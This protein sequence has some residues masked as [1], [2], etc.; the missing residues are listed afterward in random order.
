M[1][2][3][4]H[5]KLAERL[6]GILQ[7]LNEGENLVIDELLATY[8]VDRRTLQRD[9]NERLA[10]LP[11]EKVAQGVYR[12]DKTL[13][14]K[15]D[16]GDI[17][18]F[19]KFASVSELFHKIDQS[20]F[21]KY[22]KDSIQVKGFDYESIQDRQYEFDQILKAIDNHY[23]LSFRYKRLKN[24]HQALA[25]DYVVEPYRLVNKKGVWY[26]IATHNGVIKTFSLTRLSFLTPCPDQVFEP[27][28]KINQRIDTSDSIYFVGTIDEVVLK[29]HPSIATY[30]LRRRIFP[31]QEI[32]R[33]MGDGTLFLVC[34]NVHEREILPQ[35]RY[36]IPHIEIVAPTILQDRL[37]QTLTTY[38][39]HHPR[40]VAE[41]C[42][43]DSPHYHNN[44]DSHSG[45]SSL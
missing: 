37:V 33:E 14:G 26:L 28:M 40:Y 43:A 27:D 19:A 11:L 21:H 18:R 45:C 20:F 15:M 17:R 31:N 25:K 42:F 29:I 32:L 44:D 16:L 2:K 7:R 39:N 38:L 8:Q 12:L 5:E 41:P 22:L 23:A 1:A 34:K 24:A 6:A 13:M 36:W 30:F 3:G 9:L 35:I 4:K 10:F